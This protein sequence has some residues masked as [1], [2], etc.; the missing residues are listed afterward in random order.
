MDKNKDKDK[1][2]NL[3]YGYEPIEGNNAVVV[4]GSLDKETGE[5]HCGKCKSSLIKNGGRIDKDVATIMSSGGS[6]LFIRFREIAV[7]CG[8]CFDANRETTINYLATPEE[9]ENRVDLLTGEEN[10]LL[11]QI[12]NILKSDEFKK[13]GKTDYEKQRKLIERKIRQIAH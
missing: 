7:I 11:S 1:A 5:W 10:T 12:E 4:Y 3:G 9:L 8:F 13:I 6:R 2:D